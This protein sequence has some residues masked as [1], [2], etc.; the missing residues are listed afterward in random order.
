MRRAHNIQVR[1]CVWC[2]DVIW[3]MLD[4]GMVDL[5]VERA[6]EALGWDLAEKEAKKSLEKVELVGLPESDA[7]LLA[8]ALSHIPIMPGKN[9]KIAA[10]KAQEAKEKAM[11]HVSMI[12][13]FEADP[14]ANISRKAGRLYTRLS[15]LP[16]WARKQYLRFSGGRRAE[17]ADIRCCYLW[18][19]AANLR[20]KRLKRGLDIQ[21]LNELLDLIES[22]RFYEDLAKIAGIGASQAKK[23]F[24][25]LC[26]FDDTKTEHWGRNRLWF[27][28]DAICQQICDEI[29]KW[30]RQ[31]AGATRLATYCQRLEGSIMLDGLV[32]VMA[33]A[34]IPCCTIHDGCLV[35][36]GYGEIAA[37]TIRDR[38]ASIFGR[39]CFV[40]VE[41]NGEAT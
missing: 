23:S 17:S 29:S 26:L 3:R 10:K 12:R 28:L 38:S 27:A 33:E 34:G 15:S 8:V 5:M 32:P 18:C 25:V 30:R 22:G 21:S 6:K 13:L 11:K 14:A 7:D 1:Y 2:G 16:R 40:K 39:P 4:L 20:Q 9:K 41:S 24:A 36:E 37:Q 35:P 31:P 19:L